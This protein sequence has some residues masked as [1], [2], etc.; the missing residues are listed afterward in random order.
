MYKRIDIKKILS[1]EQL[2]QELMVSSIIFTQAVEGIETTREQALR[3][4]SKVREEKLYDNIK[5]N[6]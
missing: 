6:K 5:T 4:Y 1:D 3:A 2:R